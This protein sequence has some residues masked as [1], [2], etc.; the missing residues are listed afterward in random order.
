MLTGER[1]RLRP[2]PR[3]VERNVVRKIDEALVGHHMPNRDR[4]FAVRRLLAF[5]QW[6]ERREIVV[7]GRYALRRQPHDP[8]RGIAGAHAKERA[9]RCNRVDRRNAGGVHRSRPR[10]CHRNAGTQVDA[11]GLAGRQRQC[12]ITVRPQHLTVSQPSMAVTQ[13]LGALDI[14]DVSDVRRHT[15]THIHTNPPAVR[16]SC[17]AHRTVPRSD[18]HHWGKNPWRDRWKAFAS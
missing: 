4:V 6:L 2:E 3:N 9:T 11:I 18:R 5:Q 7:V 17:Q 10:T 8:H 15:D 12:G 13:F 14:T 16:R 1:Q